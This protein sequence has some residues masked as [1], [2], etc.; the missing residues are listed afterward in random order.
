M[1]LVGLLIGFA[2]V[3]ALVG[4]DVAGRTEELLGAL[5]VLGA[6]LGYAIGPMTLRRHLADLD[7][8][9]TMGVEPRDGRRPAHAADRRDR[10]PTRPRTPTRSSP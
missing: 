1:R 9:A 7:P 5:A 4:I 2:G 3:I 8:R 6:A 10:F